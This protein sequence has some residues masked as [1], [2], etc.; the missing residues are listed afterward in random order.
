MD[1][2]H[3]FPSLGAPPGTRKGALLSPGQSTR[4]A[5]VYQDLLT[6]SQA[7]DDGE[8]KS[9]LQSA[10]SLVDEALCRVSKHRWR[11]NSSEAL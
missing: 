1:S 6:L 9:A 5:M 8:L 11:P 2:F 3:L 4:L 10:A 7:A